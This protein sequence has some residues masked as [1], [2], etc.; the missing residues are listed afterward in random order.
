[1]RGVTRT[2][3]GRYRVVLGHTKREYRFF[4]TPEEAYKVL[5]IEVIESKAR[6]RFRE[7]LDASPPVAY[8]PENEKASVQK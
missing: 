5:R 7:L 2:K 6:D 3:E 1:M 4:D 8:D